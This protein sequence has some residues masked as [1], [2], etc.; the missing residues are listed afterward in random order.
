MN[1][2]KRIW[3]TLLLLLIAVV[4]NTIHI[5][6]NTAPMNTLESVK[7]VLTADAELNNILYS[8]NQ[9]ENQAQ[10]ELTNVDAEPT[11]DHAI[12]FS[13][14]Y[15]ALLNNYISRYNFLVEE[16]INLLIDIDLATK[17]RDYFR[18]LEKELI[19]EFKQVE[20]DFKTGKIAQTE[21]DDFNKLIDNAFSN[22]S[23]AE[24]N[25]QGRKIRFKELTGYA[26]P[27]GFNFESAYF[28]V[29][30][31]KIPENLHISRY[32]NSVFHIS[33]GILGVFSAE[34]IPKLKE[35]AL[36]SFTELGDA[37]VEYSKVVKTKEENQQKL[38]TGKLSKKEFIT[39][40]RAEKE[41]ILNAEIAKATYSKKLITLDRS[42]Q[43]LI[44]YY[45]KPSFNFFVSPSFYRIKAS[46]D[47]SSSKRHNETLVGRY[48]IYTNEQLQSQNKVVY[49][50]FNV[51]REIVALAKGYW[52]EYENAT[53]GKSSRIDGSVELEK[54][55][56]MGKD[57]YI[58][59]T[60]AEG[61]TIKTYSI[62]G[63]LSKGIFYNVVPKG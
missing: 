39:S 45:M 8:I 26:M 24:N 61:N 60:D 10:S 40:L 57:I 44:S 18:E 34:D 53:I 29:D 55:D 13:Y 9:K 63:F 43:G 49:K 36:K 37:V 35:D 25:L 62:N 15:T 28:I 33:G 20:I 17:K 46:E 42:M 38:K 59:F 12:Q 19:E 7:A 52:I 16:I 48:C 23:E 11:V 2:K 1:I 3:G 41:A 50:N 31:G 5:P 27:T 4:I 54:Q 32:E 56:Y 22:K 21:R 30:Y 51:P 6:A 14:D 47:E 58:H